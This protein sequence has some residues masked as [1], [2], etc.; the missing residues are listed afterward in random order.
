MLEKK[1]IAKATLVISIFA[2]VGKALG[3]I[4]EIIIA[5]FFGTTYKTDAY[6]IGMAGPDFIRE[7][8]SG[9][10][11][12][13]VFIP[14][15]T[16]SLASGNE[17]ETKKL[18]NTT[19]TLVLLALTASAL[20][21][22]PLAP[23]IV[24][25]IAPEIDAQTFGL[26]VE[27]TRI[28][29]PAIIFMGLAS[30]YGNLLNVRRHFLTPSLNHTMLNSGII[31]GVVL[32]TARFG[33]RSLALGFLLGAVLQLVVML[34]SLKEKAVSFK[35]DLLITPE[36]KKMFIIWMPLFVASF[37]ATA[38]DLVS[39]SLAAGIGQGNVAGITFANRIRE[40]IWL[41]CAVP[42]GTAVFPYL[43]EYA[44][45]NDMK[46][47]EKTISF[48][49]RLTAFLALP[50]CLIMFFYSEPI[51]RLMFQRGQFN[52]NSTLI[53]SS[54][55]LYY[56]TGALFY[57]L[58]YVIFRVYYSA[59][60]SKTPLYICTAALL[61]N[62]LAGLLLRK[63]M[64]VGGIALARSLSDF[65]A[66]V[67]LVAGLWMP[68]FFTAMISLIISV[69]VL[70]MEVIAVPG[71]FKRTKG[72]WNLV[73]YAS[74]VSLIG[75]IISINGIISGIIGAIIGWYILFQVKDLY[76]N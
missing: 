33:I 76:K 54:A 42:L 26:A 31:V 66:F 43:S 67:L 38:N 5:A 17:A 34:P 24:K 20:L 15:Y 14:V 29:F 25:A 46:E 64:M 69:I 74:I 39:R 47:L 12:T 60:D 22:F 27:I 65:T 1:Q 72:G 23:L 35:L 59:Q 49:I 36:I 9:S 28:I 11:L 48:S 32:L 44:A 41:L 40:T 2:V 10:I 52:G 13:A 18:L 62:I 7:I 8:I 53:T 61:I 4:R 57:A 71:L 63:N 6:F 21:G 19:V 56:S 75:S 16:A 3:F 37:V 58:N 55:L 51:V 50:L 68:H 70:V 30:F 45:K 73:F